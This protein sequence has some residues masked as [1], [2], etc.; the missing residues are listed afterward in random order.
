[1]QGSSQAAST[2][3]LASPARFA[4]QVTAIVVA[5]YVPVMVTAATSSTVGWAA[6]IV[7]GAALGLLV[8]RWGP[9]VGIAGL[10]PAAALVSSGLVEA[11][12]EYMP[13]VA[14]G[15]AI[16]VGAGIRLV[17]RRLPPT[18]AAMPVLVLVAV[19]AY[20]AWAAVV[21]VSSTARRTSLVYLFGMALVLGLAFVL[22][23]RWLAS[24]GARRRIL[25]VL[26]AIGLVS[27]VLTYATSLLGPL[28]VF[29]A[30]TSEALLLEL[31]LG[32]HPTGVILPWVSGLYLAQ[33]AQYQAL[34]VALVAAL[35]LRARLDATWRRWLAVAAVALAPALFLTL[36]RAGWLMAAVACVL[37]GLA[38]LWRRRPAGLSLA[39]GALFAVLAVAQVTNLLGANARFDLQAARGWTQAP[40][41]T[42]AD[43]PPPVVGVHGNVGSGSAGDAQVRGGTDLSS[44]A[45]LW[46]ASTD[47]VRQR[48]ITGYGP[49]MD[50][51]AIAPFIKSSYASYRGVTSHSTWLRTA[52][53]MGV[54]GLALLALVWLAVAVTALRGWFAGSP[55]LEDVTLGTLAAIVIALLIDQSV[56]TYLLGGL[57]FSN[58][59]W[60]M[61]LGLLAWSAQ[62]RG[63]ER[64]AGVTGPR[65][66]TAI[67]A[68]QPSTARDHS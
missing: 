57:T 24:P 65:P 26:V 47:A 37:V 50:A 19:S 1:M 41:T 33:G 61:A 52:V 31:T 64:A 44:R 53:E 18:P 28:R 34:V 12:S 15:V 3:D 22:T 14:C 55:M 5:A 54:P 17:E 30:Q 63:A 40:A 13:A 27:A 42:Q 21:T 32:R 38:Q 60:A 36:S 59:V 58:T 67:R 11:S 4:A 23:P 9:E 56:E 45:V 51:T 62:S 6:V 48:P 25:A 2:P 16:G 46:L 49:G 8:H 29:P 7:V 43:A 68:S 35:G 20:V 10:L 66:S 39:F